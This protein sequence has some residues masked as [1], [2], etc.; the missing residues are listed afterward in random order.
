MRVSAP[1]MS[2]IFDGILMRVSRKALRMHGHPQGALWKWHSFLWFWSMRWFKR[3]FANAEHYSIIVYITECGAACLH[4]ACTHIFLDVSRPTTTTV[5]DYNSLAC[6]TYRFPIRITPK[7]ATARYGVAYAVRQI[8][9][10]S[11]V[12]ATIVVAHTC[13]CSWTGEEWIFGITQT[14]TNLCYNIV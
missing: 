2:C 11:C 1:Y 4:F 14:I 12:C 9:V 10:C 6:V 3:P 13:L 5:P 8:S 7:G